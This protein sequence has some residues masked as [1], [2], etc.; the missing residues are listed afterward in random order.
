MKN[1]EFN[2]T[3]RTTCNSILEYLEVKWHEYPVSI[4][5]SHHNRDRALYINSPIYFHDNPASFNPNSNDITYAISMKIVAK[6]WR[7]QNVVL[8]YQHLSAW[9][10]ALIYIFNVQIWFKP[11]S[12]PKRCWVWQFCKCENCHMNLNNAVL[13]TISHMH[14]SMFVESA[15]LTFTLIKVHRWNQVFEWNSSLHH[16]VRTLW[17]N[18]CDCFN[19]DTDNMWWISIR[20]WYWNNWSLGFDSTWQWEVTRYVNL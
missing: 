8:T 16:V 9:L 4:I 17:M 6:Y 3:R 2:H 18:R 5:T 1:S 13:L 15:I 10:H 7:P 11:W 12:S 20:W 14:L 19:Y